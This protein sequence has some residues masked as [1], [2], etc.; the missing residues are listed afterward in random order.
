[1]KFIKKY[2]KILIGV[3]VLILVITVFFFAQRGGSELETGTLNNWRAAAM[4]R[5]VAAAQILTGGNTDV[6]LLVACVD[7]MAT[8][9]DAGEM[10]VRDAVSLCYT[11]M[12]LKENL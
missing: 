12:Q 11:G 3:A 1:M 4:D 2:F 9:P 10:V 6:E 8:L 5:R 7:K